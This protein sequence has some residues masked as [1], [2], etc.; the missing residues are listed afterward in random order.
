[1]EVLT[2]LK[3]GGGG[4]MLYFTTASTNVFY[5]AADFDQIDLYYEEGTITVQ[6]IGPEV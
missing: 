3:K 4:I 6:G 2:R 5:P 1:M